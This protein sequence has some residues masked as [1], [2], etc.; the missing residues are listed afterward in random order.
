MQNFVAPRGHKF[1]DV[2][3]LHQQKPVHS[4]RHAAT[5]L[6]QGYR[7][8]LQALYRP[9]GSVN[10]G[11]YHGQN[12]RTAPLE[13][14]RDRVIKLP[15]FQKYEKHKDKPDRTYHTISRWK[16]F[17]RTLPNDRRRNPLELAKDALA[18]ICVK[19]NA[20][21]EVPEDDQHELR[22]WG[23]PDVV[24][25]AYRS[26]HAW[27]MS[28]KTSGQS[29]KDAN[30]WFKQNALDGREEHRLLRGT[31]Q[32]QEQE[33]FQLYA[34]DA[35]LQFEMYLLWPPGYDLENFI[36]DYDTGAL[37]TLRQNFKCVITH[38]KDVHPYTRI[39]GERRA[40]VF[41]VYH[42]LLTLQRE[43]VARKK[44]GLRLTQCR[45][46]SASA[47]RDQIG[48]QRV[49]LSNRPSTYAFQK[50][51]LLGPELPNDK[52]EVENWN[53]LKDDIQRKYRIAG[54]TA[55][56][57]CID[58]LHVSEKHVRMRV[59]FGDIVL[60]KYKRPKNGAEVYH[61]NEFI[62][63]V[64]QP[65]LQVDQAALI[66]GPAFEFLDKLESFDEL[67]PDL[68]ISGSHISWAV[69]FSF[70]SGQGGTLRLEVEFQANGEE[71][72]KSAV[73]WLNHSAHATQDVVHLLQVFNMDL[74]KPGYQLMVT[75]VPLYTNP[76][77]LRDLR[78]FEKEVDLKP[79]RS[80]L[81][82]APTKQSVYPLTNRE[83]S[84]VDEVTIAK[85][86]YKNTDGILELRRFDHFPQGPGEAN[87][88]PAYTEWRAAYYYRGWDNLLT[89]F[90]NIGQGTDVEWKRDLS[91]FFPKT[92]DA[93]D[94]P[95]G[96]KNFVKEVEEI[97][98]LL[99]QALS[100][101]RENQ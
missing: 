60:D 37:S 15:A 35:M 98:V 44:T 20:F 30:G 12:I 9:S 63:M 86:R 52:Q 25:T 101:D 53:T 59:S 56:R 61:I 26:L 73:R 62:E 36:T 6:P 18:E 84:S 70:R 78:S 95:N 50:P 2:Q 38:Q 85:Y 24:D 7:P 55:L 64:Q 58:S 83:L 3:K 21:I 91:T 45:L 31:L 42:R 67:Q 100:G 5:R 74:E 82:F 28:V 92:G 19:T 27:E 46:P 65:E 51:F 69:N 93:M 41:Q 49:Q 34:D 66:N 77:T 10:T 72:S 80:G 32:R 81:R 39:A 13:L 29:R 88:L 90:A 17:I 48:L 22:I 1:E 14:P 75:A 47:Y 23:D 43:M 8:N 16:D 54:K 40:Q 11:Q 79:A 33:L 99:G 97:Q 87:A 71:T 57:S 89:E 94:F 96:Y 76:K 68:G 4:K